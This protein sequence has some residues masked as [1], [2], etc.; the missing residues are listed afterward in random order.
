[1]GNAASVGSVIGAYKYVKQY[2]NI[3]DEVFLKGNSMGGLSSMSVACSGEIPI[4][5]EVQ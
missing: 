5:A 1:M 3:Y 4:L 2:Y